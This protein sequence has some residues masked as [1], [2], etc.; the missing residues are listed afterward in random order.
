MSLEMAMETW[1]MC[2]RQYFP[3]LHTNTYFLP[4]VSDPYPTNIPIIMQS[5]TPPYFTKLRPQSQTDD[6]LQPSP[7]ADDSP[8]DDKND[9]VRVLRCLRTLG[10]RQ[11]DVMVVL[12][13][14]KFGNNRLRP[15][16]AP[17]TVFLSQSA[18]L[19]CEYN[20]GD[21]DLLILHSKYGLIVVEGTSFGTSFS[22]SASAKQGEEAILAQKV[23]NALKRL[24]KSW[25]V[26]THLVREHPGVNVVKTLVFPNVTKSRVLR[27]VS[28]DVK[29]E[30]VWRRPQR[31]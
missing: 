27:A 7:H 4:Q 29:V 2:T 16:Y 13:H 1:T 18:A 31:E 14:M 11:G 8:R 17:A 12:S 20:D 6:N 26:L 25:N 30:N 10:E 9:T 28:S 5:N 24:N 23:E 21:I 19:D 3:K 15:C 22:N